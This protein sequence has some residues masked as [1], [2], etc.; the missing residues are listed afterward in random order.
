MPEP[1]CALAGWAQSRILAAL[2]QLL[3]KR[4]SERSVDDARQS[5]SAHS[6][7]ARD[8]EDRLEALNEQAERCRRLAGATY[9]RDVAAMLG[10]MAEGFEKTA[11]E[12]SKGRL[13]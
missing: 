4:H 8:L 6:E 11:E 10:A 7:R 1:A 2:G 5:P 12:L 13:T 3:A 9:D